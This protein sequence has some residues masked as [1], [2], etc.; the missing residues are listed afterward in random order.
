VAQLGGTHLF[1]THEVAHVRT[2][3]AAM[4]SLDVR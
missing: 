1:R 3:L 4:A 2:V